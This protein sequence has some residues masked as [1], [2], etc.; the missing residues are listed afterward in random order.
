MLDKVPSNNRGDD[1]LFDLIFIY[2]N[3]QIKIL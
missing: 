3:N 1:F 2:K